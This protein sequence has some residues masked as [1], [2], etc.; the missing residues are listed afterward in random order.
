ML[1]TTTILAGLIPMFFR[2]FWWIDK[3]TIFELND[4]AEMNNFTDQ[5]IN[6]IDQ[7]INELKK[8]IK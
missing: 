2:K 5:I 6:E 7:Y 3:G 4:E 8:R 1:L